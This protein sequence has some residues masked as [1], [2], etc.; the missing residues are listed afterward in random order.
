MPKTLT[1]ICICMHVY[2]KSA[3]ILKAV[4]FVFQEETV[5][6][7]WQSCG[8]CVSDWR[9]AD[10]CSLCHFWITQVWPWT[11]RRSNWHTGKSP[12]VNNWC[13]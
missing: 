9:N 1:S 4:Y 13:L 8:V 3:S 5:Q 11:P 2:K 12:V 7:T 10:L 6:R